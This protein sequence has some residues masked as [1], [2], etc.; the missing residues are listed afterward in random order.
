MLNTTCQTSPNN[1]CNQKENKKN[2]LRI[3]LNAIEVDS[4]NLNHSFSL[5]LIKSSRNTTSP[6]CLN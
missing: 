5:I 4:L 3:I 2:N 6:A 1:I